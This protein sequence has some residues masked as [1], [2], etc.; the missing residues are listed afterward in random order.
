MKTKTQ[1][2]DLSGLTPLTHSER[3]VGGLKRL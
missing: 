3:G 1:N 2:N